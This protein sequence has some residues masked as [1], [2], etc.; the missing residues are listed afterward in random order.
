MIGILHTYSMSTVIVTYK[1]H[2]YIKRIRWFLLLGCTE[3]IL[4]KILKFLKFNWLGWV[5]YIR[6][7]FVPMKKFR[8]GVQVHKRTTWS[9]MTV[10]VFMP[11]L[12]PS[13]RHFHTFRKIVYHWVGFGFWRVGHGLKVIFF[14]WIFFGIAHSIFTKYRSG[15]Y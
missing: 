4:V 13:L 9:K 1:R 10:R 11:I 7:L 3:F 5:T 12:T 15:N 2:I 8:L 6:C 14:E